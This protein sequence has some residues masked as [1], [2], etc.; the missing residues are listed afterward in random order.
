VQSKREKLRKLFNYFDKDHSDEIDK[1]EFKQLLIRVC[2]TFGEEIPQDDKLEY[3]MASADSNWDGKISFE[4][5]VEF[6]KDFPLL[7][8][9]YRD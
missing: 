6:M 2:K 4:E 3:I 7:L 5:F 8:E 9:M 1:K